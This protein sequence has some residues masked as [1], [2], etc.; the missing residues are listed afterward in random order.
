MNL[1]A[2]TKYG[3]RAASARQRYLQYAEHLREAGINLHT[4]PLLDNSYLDATFSGRA[5]S[6]LSVARSYLRRLR[7]LLREREADAVWLQYEFFPYAP[8]FFETLALSR[9][10]P[11]ILD[12]DDAIFHQYAQHKNPIVR[13]MLG[14]KL[15]PLLQQAHLA[16]CGNAYLQDYAAQYCR[17]TDIVPTVVDTDVYGTATEPQAD[18]PLTVGWIGSPSTWEFAKP[19][20]G[21]LTELARRLSLTV[22]VVG[23]GPQKDIPPRFEFL[24]W[25]EEE[26]IRLIQGMHIGI[27][28]LPDE[29]WARGKC[30]YK[31]IQ[32]MACE[33][34]VVASPVGVNTDIVDHGSNGFLAS[35]PQEWAEALTA[36]AEDAALRRRMGAEGR[37]KIEQA[38]SLAVHGPRLAKLLREVI[39]ESRSHST[40]NQS[41]GLMRRR[42][43]A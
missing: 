32:Y 26:E 7:G 6:K 43:A 10:I 35:G 1:L 42:C 13:L 23:A 31:L 34:P 28:P 14:G 29:P 24:P 33:L 12:Y 19:L 2:C 18:R 5:A 11:L 40:Q 36:L 37:R 20:I 8:G 17:W 16:I 41:E 38:Y 21:L 22:R 39:E 4:A 3:D 15:K 27:M 30:G 25:S 9:R